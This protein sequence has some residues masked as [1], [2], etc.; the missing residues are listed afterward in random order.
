MRILIAFVMALLSLQSA[1]AVTV[2]FSSPPFDVAQFIVNQPG[3]FIGIRFP[4]VTNVQYIPGTFG[5]ISNQQVYLGTNT[6]GGGGGGGG[7]GTLT[8]VVF[9][10]AGPDTVVITGVSWINTNKFLAPVDSRAITNLNT[11]FDSFSGNVIVKSLGV[12]P[13]P[14]IALNANGSAFFA[15]GN[16]QVD[17]G[18]NWTAIS[19]SGDGNLLTDLNASELATG[20]APPARLGTGT[21]NALKFLRGDSFWAF[22]VTNVLY[23]NAGPATLLVDDTIFLNT[24]VISG[25]PGGGGISQLTGDVTAGPGTGSQVAT[26]ATV[27]VSPA[28]YRSVTANAKGLVTAGSNPTTFAGYAISDSWANLGAVLTGVLPATAFPALTGDITTSAGSLATTLKNTGTAGT[29]RSTTFD[30]QGRETSG[31]NPTTFAGYAISDTWPNLA[32]A[33]TLLIPQSALGTGSAGT[34]L[35]FLADDQTYKTV[36]S[37][38]TTALS[39]TNAIFPSVIGSTGYIPNQVYTAG[40]LSP[41]Y[42]RAYTSAGMT[43]QR[44]KGI[45]AADLNADGFLD[46]VVTKDAQAT[47]LVTTNQGYGVFPVGTSFNLPNALG[48]QGRPGLADLD[49]NNSVDIIMA[50]ANSGGSNAIFVFKNNGTGSGF[51]QLGST[52]TIG[53]TSTQFAYDIA[54]GQFNNDTNVDFAFAASTLVGVY[55][56]DVTGLFALS[57]STAIAVANTV[58]PEQVATGDFNGD[59][60]T[61]IMVLDDTA[62]TAAIKVYTNGPGGFGQFALYYTKNL[63]PTSDTRPT[64]VVGDVNGDGKPDYV[65]SSGLAANHVVYTYTNTG[66]LATQ[67]A[68]CCT[69]TMT[70]NLIKSLSLGDVNMDGRQDLAV[71]QDTVFTVTTLTNNGGGNFV[72]FETNTLAATS[73]ALLADLNSDLRPDLITGGASNPGIVLQNLVDVVGIFNGDFGAN[74]NLFTLTTGNSSTYTAGN[75]SSG[76]ANP[77]TLQLNTNFQP[78][79]AT[80]A[81]VGQIGNGLGVTNI[82][83]VTVSAATSGTVTSL[84]THQVETT[85]MSSGS[86]I[87]SMTW[88]LPTSTTLGKVFYLHSKSAITTLTITGG[89]FIDAA[90]IAMTAGQTIGFQTIDASGQYLRLQ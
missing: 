79:V 9:T 4:G 58:D 28:T 38:G 68:A 81:P 2:N 25:G 42:F 41:G 62:G 32:A 7:S 40:V 24:N 50:Q 37:G 33:L 34:G 88:A 51:T 66:V 83:F 53:T 76:V 13:T 12:G 59:G 30:A 36:S 29:Y 15:A 73:T 85:Y 72:A 46:L 35:K 80:F 82:F 8:N 31:S 55:T 26:L 65:V 52:Y 87:V 75:F 10:N 77:A 56:N 61:D 43:G 16:S 64:F 19:F 3:N 22:A 54:T 20:L 45:G 78:Y 67:F 47:F 44:A 14:N 27:L 57:W 60:L 90:V 48:T 11:G 18:G 6:F 21:P 89:S 63:V 84:N 69:N 74:S 71:C 70:A 1:S 17:S 49:G 39:P 5:Y 86:T 23:T